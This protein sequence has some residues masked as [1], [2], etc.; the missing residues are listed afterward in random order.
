MKATKATKKNERG[1]PP[2]IGQETGNTTTRI[3]LLQKY[4][5]F[6]DKMGQD[7]PEDKKASATAQ[8]RKVGQLKKKLFLF[9]FLEYTIKYV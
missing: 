2:K 6:G 3:V 9:P 7:L 5:I 4:P 8:G 1:T